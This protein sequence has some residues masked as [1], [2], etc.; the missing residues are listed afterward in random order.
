MRRN[1]IL[2]RRISFALLLVSLSLCLCSMSSTYSRYISSTQSNIDI[3]FAK[4]QILINDQD[5][6]DQNNSEIEITPTIEPNVNVKN[7]V[8]APSSKGYF[9]IDIDP[10]SVDVSFQYTI[11]LDI[12]NEDVPDLIISKYAI[13]PEDF[14][15][16]DTLEYTTIQN[17]VISN[18][19]IFDNETNNFQFDPFTVRICF[20]WFEGDD[21]E[22]DDDDDS[23]IGADDDASFSITATL[24]F[25]QII[26]TDDDD[27]SNENESNNENNNQEEPEN[28]N[29]ET[30]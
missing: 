7:D 13:L 12:D 18:Q 5:I 24:S 2:R 23:L 10:S 6:Q 26:A 8:V 25:E 16:G 19:M 20:E 4:W 9:D 15:E 17:N 27:E 11:T 21:E 1:I 22:M 3:M 14:E 28:N 30:P 29:E